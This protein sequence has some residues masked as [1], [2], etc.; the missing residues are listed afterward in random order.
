LS[1]IV[2]LSNH[3]HAL[4]KSWFLIHD[5]LSICSEYSVIH[6]CILVFVTV[7]QPVSVV[8]AVA[9]G[10]LAV[11]FVKMLARDLVQVLFV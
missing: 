2:N 9:E 5:P 11:A 4:G 8:T 10:A 3:A 1:L 6:P 7:R